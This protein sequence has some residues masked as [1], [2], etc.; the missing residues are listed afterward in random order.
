MA[1]PERQLTVNSK[2]LAPSSLRVEKTRS[3]VAKDIP[4]WCQE[5]QCRLEAALRDYFL[6]NDC[7]EADEAEG[8]QGKVVMKEADAHLVQQQLSELA[9][10][11][12]YV[13]QACNEE[14][15]VLEEEFDFLTNG[16]LIMESQMQT[17]KVRIDSKVSG[18]GLVMQFQQAMLQEICLGIHILQGQDNQIVSEATELFAGVRQE[19]E[20][21][22]KRICDNT[23]QILA[24][25]SSNKGIQKTFAT[26]SLRI[27]E[28]N[29]AMAAITISLKNIPSMR[30]LRQHQDLREDQLAQVDEV[31]A[32]LTPAMEAYKVSESTPFHVAHTGPSGTHTNVHPERRRA[33]ANPSL[34]VSSLRDT[35]SDVSWRGILRGGAGSN[36]AAGGADGGAAGGATGGAAG[37]G[38]NGNTG[39]P[40]RP[41]D[42]P[43]SDHGGNGGR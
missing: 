31:D 38:G 27:D 1:A 10:Q 3:S 21:L 11:V 24:V 35:E 25:K 22:S 7:E 15:D 14:N 18:V 36:G 5:Y 40:P 13:I 20:A 33:M 16:I 43:P 32:G 29:K 37:D 39:D 23:L 12:V 17:K 42:P 30:E 9:K 26:V 41:G 6:L 28:V 19:Q 2:A 34:S 4:E 8:G